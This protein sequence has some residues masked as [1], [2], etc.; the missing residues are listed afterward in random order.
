MRTHTT[1]ARTGL[2][3]LALGL[4]A[5]GLPSAASAAGRGGDRAQDGVSSRV[6]TKL[7]SVSRGLDRAE[8][9]VEDGDATKAASSLASVRRSLAS[10]QR[11]TLRKVAADAD[12]AEANAVAVERAEHAVVATTASLYDGRTGDVVTALSTTLDAALDGRDALIA[13]V[14]ALDDEQAEA[15][16]RYQAKVLRDVA[17][18]TE[19]VADATADDELT[20]DATAALAEATTRLAAQGTAAGALVAATDDDAD[21]EGGVVAGVTD[22]A[23][24]AAGVA[25]DCGP[26]G[27]RSG[28][29]GA[30]SGQDDTGTTD[31]TGT[32]GARFGGRA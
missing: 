9:Y 32:T 28:R 4:C 31:T 27:G 19:D 13:G 12:G 25:A 7:R 20:G 29:G 6:Q 24:D 21:D 10:A 16:D 18:E 17:A 26:R 11:T 1:I 22:A 30:A 3:I 8:G 2:A 5:A 14:D 15:Y 23:A